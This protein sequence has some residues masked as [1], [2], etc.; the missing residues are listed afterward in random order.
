MFLVQIF[1]IDWFA[2]HSTGTDR[3]LAR[4]LKRLWGGRGVSPSEEKREMVQ[5]GADGNGDGSGEGKEEKKEGG[6]KRGD[7]A[8]VVGS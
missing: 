4:Y 8:V 5:G 7:S 6:E 1:L 3:H 2:N